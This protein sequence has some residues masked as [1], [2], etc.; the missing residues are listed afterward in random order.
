MPVKMIRQSIGHFTVDSMSDKVNAILEK[1]HADKD[2]INVQLD[3]IRFGCNSSSSVPSMHSV[4][5]IIFY[6]E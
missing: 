1:E 6:K 2:I 3:I 5:L 4:Y